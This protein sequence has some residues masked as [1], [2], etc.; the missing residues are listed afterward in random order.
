MIMSVQVH[1]IDVK[2]VD[3]RGALHY[4]QQIERVNFYWYIEMRGQ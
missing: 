3:E 4:L 2:A 1:P